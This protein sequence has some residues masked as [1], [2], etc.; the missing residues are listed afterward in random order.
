[1]INSFEVNH[2]NFVR[3]VKLIR[4]VLISIKSNESNIILKNIRGVDHKYHLYIS[5]Y[6]NRYYINNECITDVPFFYMRNFESELDSAIS[7]LNRVVNK[8]LVNNVSYVHRALQSIESLPVKYRGIQQ[9]EHICICGNEMYINYISYELVCQTCGYVK[10]V[11]LT[12]NDSIYI[13]NYQDIHKSSGYDPGRHCR[14]WVSRIQARERIEIPNKVLNQLNLH[15]F[16]N[17]IRDVREITCIKIRTFLKELKLTEYNDNIPTIRKLLTGITPPELKDA[18]LRQ[19]YSL[20]NSAVRSFETHRPPKKSNTPY[21]PY[22]IY[23]ILDITLSQGTRKKKILECIHLQSRNTLIN[24][25]KIWELICRDLGIMYKSTD[26]S[27]QIHSFI[28]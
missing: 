13:N 20:F 14:F 2:N 24:N 16:K 7:F 18:E 21:Y 15:I 1:M 4:E 28:F 26:R 9:N 23:K 27:D 5:K 6:L 3:K 25:D 11:K 12:L 19:L 8:R 22:F 10:Y 17:R